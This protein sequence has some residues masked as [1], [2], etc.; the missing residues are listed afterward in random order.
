MLL[1]KIGQSQ[2]GGGPR[3]GLE[4]LAKDFAADFDSAIVIAIADVLQQVRHLGEGTPLTVFGEV[5]L[6]LWTRGGRIG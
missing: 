5:L 2:L 3:A 4:A 6:A 1:H